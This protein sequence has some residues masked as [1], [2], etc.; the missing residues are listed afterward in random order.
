MIFADFASS[1]NTDLNNT[2]T[3]V[4]M[5]SVIIEPEIATIINLNKPLEGYEMLELHFEFLGRHS[6]ST[7]IPIL[8]SENKISY[9]IVIDS[10]SF[11]SAYLFCIFHNSTS[12]E[13][14]VKWGENETGANHYLVGILASK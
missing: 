7:K 9:G 6:I 13:L 14:T 4:F 3:T 12:I 11:S 5:D 2:K 10:C 8:N 1:L